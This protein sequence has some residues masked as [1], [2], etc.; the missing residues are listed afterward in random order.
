MNVDIWQPEL[1]LLPEEY[2]FSF[3]CIL[4]ATQLSASKSLKEI[5][6]GERSKFWQTENIFLGKE[7]LHMA[8]SL[9]K[10]K[11][12]KQTFIGKHTPL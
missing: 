6:I 1:S 7:N 8:L 12:K 4:Q 9:Y 10:K 5:I 11:K 3:A 2:L